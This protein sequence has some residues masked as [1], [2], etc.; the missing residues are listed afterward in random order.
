[1]LGG[2]GSAAAGKTL[3]R[4]VTRHHWPLALAACRGLPPPDARSPRPPSRRRPRLV[5]APPAGSGPLRFA[6]GR[7]LEVLGLRRRAGGRGF[8]GRATRGR[9][10]LPLRPAPMPPPPKRLYSTWS[11]G[12]SGNSGHEGGRWTEPRTAP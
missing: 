9:C 7:R 3:A 11:L 10:F 6:A 1:V 2:R 4:S 12:E 5:A 8:C